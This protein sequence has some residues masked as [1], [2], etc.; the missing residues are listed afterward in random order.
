LNFTYAFKCYQQNV[1]GFTL[2]GPPCIY[3]ADSTMRRSPGGKIRC[4]SHYEWRPR[5]TAT[6]WNH[7]RLCDARR[8]S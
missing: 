1:S 2:A 3:I 4:S 8:A 6:A 7:A 5:W